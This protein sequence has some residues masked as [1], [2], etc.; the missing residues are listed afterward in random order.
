MID[1]TLL[2]EIVPSGLSAEARISFVIGLNFG[3]SS[4]RPGPLEAERQVVRELEVLV[5]SHARELDWFVRGLTV[6]FE[7]R[8]EA[9]RNAAA[10]SRKLGA[11]VPGSFL[12]ALLVRARQCEQIFEALSSPERQLL[13]SA[14]RAR[15]GTDPEQTVRLICG[16]GRAQ[17]V[18]SYLGAGPSECLQED[19][20][21][22]KWNVQPECAPGEEV[23]ALHDAILGASP[24]WPG[25]FFLGRSSEY[26][27]ALELLYS[28]RFE[29]L[30]KALRAR[31]SGLERE[32]LADVVSEGKVAWGKLLYLCVTGIGTDEQGLRDLLRE[33]SPHDRQNARAEFTRLWYRHAPWYERPFPHILGDLERRIW[34]E[35]G[36]DAFFELTE[37]LACTSHDTVTSFE[38]VDRMY[39]HERSGLLLRRV[40]SFVYEGRVMD[41]DVT[42]TREFFR[43]LCPCADGNVATELRGQMLVRFCEIDCVIFRSV[44]H[45]L[46]NN[47]TSFVAAVCAG[48]AAIALTLEH[49][50]VATIMIVV[51]TISIVVRL[52]LK[53]LLKGRGYHPGELLVD[54]LF[55]AVDGA[56]LFTT[57]LFRQTLLRFSTKC[58]TVLG[59]RTGLLKVSRL[60]GENRATRW[61]VSLTELGGRK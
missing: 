44:K 26:R 16:D 51:A 59:A 45:A 30:D 35:T 23:E 60:L 21:P 19:S 14:F 22:N 31:F 36:G 1:S 50:E 17:R 42:A 41:R 13:V 12:R 2:D 18:C 9:E 27:R 20:V 37:Y 39:R 40:D 11:L 34:I 6:G 55:G 29:F 58:L 61:G 10:L 3:A 25:I 48:G 54:V 43:T 8:I 56:T 33:M 49:L 24:L 4:E 32:I 28:E 47:V 46:G 52:S 53:R 5:S 57:Y 38:R 15:Y 7:H